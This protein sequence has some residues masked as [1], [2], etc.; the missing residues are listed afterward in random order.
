MSLRSRSRFAVPLALA[1]A[2][3]VPAAPAAA[4]DDDDRGRGHRRHHYRGHDHDRGHDRHHDRGHYRH[5]EHYRHGGGHGH[6]HHSGCG[7]GWRGPRVV[8]HKYYGYPVHHYGY[9]PAAYCGPCG[10]HFASYDVLSHHVHHHHH[11]AAIALPSV[12]FQASIGGGVGWVY[13]D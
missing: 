4:D 2:L 6:R 7:H 12:I 9:A 11:I 5:S 1:A 8:K 3:L 10:H 13:D